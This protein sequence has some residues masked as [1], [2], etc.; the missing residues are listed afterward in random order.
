MICFLY[1]ASSIMWF[2]GFLSEHFLP[3]SVCVSN[4][5]PVRQPPRPRMF[6]YPHLPHEAAH[7]YSLNGC[8]GVVLSSSPLLFLVLVC[9]GYT[10][11]LATFTSSLVY[12]LAIYIRKLRSSDLHCGPARPL[13]CNALPALVLLVLHT[14][15]SAP[16]S[17]CSN[18][19]SAA[20]TF[21][22]HASLFS[23]CWR[24][25]RL[26]PS[27]VRIWSCR[28]SRVHVPACCLL[29]MVSG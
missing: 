22:D 24:F 17:V 9:R 25:K 27:G 12:L 2:E 18:L 7:L 16:L 11:V 29:A 21:T 19:C 4:S 14:F 8:C 6:I 3:V 28:I 15:A 26:S 20:L 10:S 5:L 13:L 1:S 23:P